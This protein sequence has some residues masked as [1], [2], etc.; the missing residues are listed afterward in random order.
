MSLFSRQSNSA[1]IVRRYVATVQ[2]AMRAN[3][4]KI[5]ARKQLAQSAR[6]R[7]QLNEP[8]STETKS[9]D[10]TEIEIVGAITAGQNV[11]SQW[12]RQQTTIARDAIEA[13]I[14]QELAVRNVLAEAAAEFSNARAAAKDELIDARVDERKAFRALKR[15]KLDNGLT[16]DASYSDSKLFTAAVLIAAIVLE[17]GF[18]A[19]FLSEWMDKGYAEGAMLALGISVANVVVLGYLIGGYL[20]VRM[21]LHRSI[22]LKLLGIVLV[23]VA[24]SATLLL[25]TGFALLRDALDAGAASLNQAMARVIQIPVVDWIRSIRTPQSLLL[26][27]LGSGCA[28]A[29]AI[30]GAGLGATYDRYIG[31]API[32]KQHDTLDEVYKDMKS[33]FRE[34]VEDALEPARKKLREMQAYDEARLREIA[35]IATEVEALEAEIA[36]SQREWANEGHRLIKAY[37]DENVNVRTTPTPPIWSSLPELVP[38]EPLNALIDLQTKLEEARAKVDRNSVVLQEAEVE[39]T[40]IQSHEAAVFFDEVEDA[41]A[42]AEKRL[43][44]NDKV[45]G[46]EVE[47]ARRNPKAPEVLSPA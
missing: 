11:L 39:L 46:D 8:K 28:I 22:S 20:G 35:T 33:Y 32:Q 29:G 18:N 24:L 37:R 6:D 4:E 31:F 15:F 23:V 41:E 44:K 27:I 38:Q 5:I 36:E 34:S 26:A 21:A 42:Q 1:S 30:K 17:A 14:P 25:N 7:G 47:A 45:D 16:R 2:K 13:R 12:G 3:G 19:T 43:A 40:K 10:P 9:L